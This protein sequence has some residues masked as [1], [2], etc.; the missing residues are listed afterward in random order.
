MRTLVLIG[1]GILL[2]ACQPLAPKTANDELI[3]RTSPHSVAETMDRLEAAVTAKGAKVFARIN[4][5]A[6]AQSIGEVL[7][8][9]EV[10]IFGNPE[11]GTPL[12]QI[13][14]RM[15]LDLPVKI[16][17]WDDN[18]QTRIVFL[19]PAKLGAWYGIEATNPVLIK[20]R[21]VLETVSKEASRED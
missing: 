19:N 10:L 12:M 8:A 7:T 6:G 15:G 17:V 21:G 9:E 3:T 13:D 16:L 20:M 2:A 1:I 5:G 18:G 4:H 11:L 14:P